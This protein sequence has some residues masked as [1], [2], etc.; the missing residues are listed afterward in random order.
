MKAGAERF[1][2]RMRACCNM[3]QLRLLLSLPSHA[4]ADNDCIPN[5]AISHEPAACLDTR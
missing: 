3:I 5:Q 2:I 4:Q 1:I